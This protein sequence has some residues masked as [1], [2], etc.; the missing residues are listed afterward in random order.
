M[1]HISL[2][3]AYSGG[4][5]SARSDRVSSVPNTGACSLDGP[6]YRSLYIVT[7]ALARALFHLSVIGRDHVPGTGPAVVVANHL[8]WIDPVLLALALPRKPAFLAMEELWRMPVIKFIL[9][10]YRL[11]IPIRRGV[12]DATALRQAIDVLRQGALLIVFPEGGIS[13]DGRLKPFHRGAA[14]LAARS[15]APIVPVALAGTREVLPLDRIVP[16]PRPVTIRIGTPIPVRG[17]SRD[18]LIRASDEAAAQI[19][20]MLGD[21]A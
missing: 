12:V 6:V 7:G 21:T 19:R 11:A 17:T 9:H 14:M 4:R 16:R 3:L 2:C 15:G 1:G 10:R 5:G 13:P 18:D 8:S 20:A